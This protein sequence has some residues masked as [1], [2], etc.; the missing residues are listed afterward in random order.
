[1]SNIDLRILHLKT[2]PILGG[3]SRDVLRLILTEDDMYVGFE[4]DI[5]TPPCADSE[6][7]LA[8][9]V[10][11]EH[12]EYVYRPVNNHGYILNDLWSSAGLESV[13]THKRRRTKQQS[14]KAQAK[15]V[16][17]TDEMVEAAYKQY[18]NPNRCGHRSLDQSKDDLRQAIQ[19]ALAAGKKGEA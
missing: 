3:M 4:P 5:D 16:E 10:T 14:L 13:A 18:W 7:P 15:G 2:I 17:V 8:D 12:D 9:G 19:A 11:F 1:M 6:P